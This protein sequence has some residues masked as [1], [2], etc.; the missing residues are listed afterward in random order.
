[1]KTQQI[2]NIMNNIKWNEPIW[3]FCSTS[4]NCADDI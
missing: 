4:N 1:M 3:K 2:E